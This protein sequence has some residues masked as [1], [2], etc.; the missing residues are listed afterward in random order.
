MAEQRR[1]AKGADER[2]IRSPEGDEH[3]TG[4]DVRNRERDRNE[5]DPA[6]GRDVPP[7]NPRPGGTRGSE[8][9]WLGGG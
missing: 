8:S 7:S 5:R 6:V 4:S 9:P 2:P 1:P 3:E